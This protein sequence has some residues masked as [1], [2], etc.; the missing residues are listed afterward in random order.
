MKHITFFERFEADILSGK[1]VITLRDESEKDYEV[2]DVVAVSTLE[3]GRRFCHVRIDGV[4]QVR[5]DALTAL[6]AEQENMTLAQLKQVIQEIY[7]GI[8]QLYMLKFS[9]MT[10]VI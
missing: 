6:H 7:P 8:E 2:G 4:T 10:D 5:F 1:K 9:L 3:H